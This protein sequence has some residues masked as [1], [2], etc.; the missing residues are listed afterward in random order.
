MRSS[1]PIILLLLTTAIV[2]QSCDSSLNID[3]PKDFYKYIGKDG[4]QTGVDLVTDTLG[5]AY[6]LGTSTIGTDTLGQQIYVVMTNSGGDVVWSKTYG[7]SGDDVPKDIEMLNDGTLIVVADRSD[8]DFTIYK[9]DQT[10]GSELKPPVISGL[11]ALTGSTTLSNDH[12]NSI[13]QTTDGFVV[14]GYS[15]KGTYKTALVARYYADLTPFAPS[16]DY[17]LNQLNSL[18]STTGYDV[19]PIKIFQKDASTFFIFGYTNTTLGADQFPDYN[20][21]VLS[22]SEFNGPKNTMLL[23]D[24]DPATHSNE[25]LS[26]VRQAP[27]QSGG[28]FILT[29]YTSSPNGSTQNIYVARVVQDPVTAQQ[30]TFIQGIPKTITS[31][32]SNLSG[33]F[34]SVCPSSSSGFYILGSE[35]VAGDNNLYLTKL[36]NDLSNAWGDN[37]PARTLGG[38]GDDAGGA[39]AETVDGRILVVGTMVL[40]DL[41]G[42]RKLVLMNLSSDGFF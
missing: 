23:I 19:V 26:S 29:G 40:G 20:Y 4:S 6:I 1:L 27:I 37:N 35:G 15:D 38:V 16:W 28:G 8:G 32:L 14:A 17:Q 22:T 24:A 21:F 30:E 33:A 39:V 13:T 7:G 2:Y 11:E 18:V 36:G 3:K 41:K 31:N 9:L 42:Q 5:N 12:A 10:N 34:V 25:R